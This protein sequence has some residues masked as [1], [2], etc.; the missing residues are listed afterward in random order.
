M[1]LVRAASVVRARR[2]FG[3]AGAHGEQEVATCALPKCSPDDC[4]YLVRTRVKHIGLEAD[5]LQE[6]DPATVPVVCLHVS[7]QMM[8]STTVVKIMSLESPKL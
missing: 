1:I 3:L 2:S 5:L 4:G 6:P 8:L 7:L